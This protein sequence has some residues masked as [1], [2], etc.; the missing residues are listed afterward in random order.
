MHLEDQDPQKDGTIEPFLTLSTS[1]QVM[2]SIPAQNMAA[3]AII[4]LT[5]SLGGHRIAPKMADGIF[6]IS[7][8]ESMAE[9]AAQE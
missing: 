6:P 4:R 9:M 7:S 3:G 5:S 2:N 1:Y 8:G